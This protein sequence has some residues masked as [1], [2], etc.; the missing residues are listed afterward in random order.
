MDEVEGTQVGPKFRPVEGDVLD[1]DDV[2][3]KFNA[4]MGWLSAV[5]VST[6]N[7]IHYMHDKYCY[8]RVQMAL[9]DEHV[10]RGD[11]RGAGHPRN[12]SL[13]VGGDRWSSRASR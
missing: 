3:D 11:Q 2:V 7:A 13:P 10:T 6:L 5:Y 12:G 9:H 4:M 1:Y 8:E